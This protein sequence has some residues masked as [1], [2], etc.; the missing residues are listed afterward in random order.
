[1][2]AKD[3]GPPLARHLALTLRRLIRDP[4]HT[5][6]WDDGNGE[7]PLGAGDVMVLVRTRNESAEVGAALRQV[8]V[9]FIALQSDDVF[10]SK[11]ALYL[12]DLLA[13]LGAPGHDG[14]QVSALVTPFFGI[15]L[16]QGNR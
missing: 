2:A 14:R 3:L 9:P 1:M 6:I 15:P 11:E 7:R 5:L 10:Q 12:R 4:E 13:S 8:G 16:E